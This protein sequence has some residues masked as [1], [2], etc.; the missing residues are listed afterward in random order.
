MNTR[1][2]VE[3]L[4]E[5][6]GDTIE[7]FENLEPVERLHSGFTHPSHRKA[8]NYFRRAHL[9]HVKGGDLVRSTLSFEDLDNLAFL[10][11]TDY[12]SRRTLRP[13]CCV[14]TGLKPGGQGASDISVYDDAIILHRFRRVPLADVRGF[15]TPK[16][17]TIFECAN[18]FI[19]PDGSYWT[20]ITFAELHSN[21]WRFQK[22]P[23]RLNTSPTHDFGLAPDYKEE[24]AFHDTEL[25]ETLDVMIGSHVTWCSFWHVEFAMPN[26]LSLLLPVNTALIPLLFRLREL[27]PHKSRRAAL[28]HLVRSHWRG[29]SELQ[30]EWEVQVAGYLR[31]KTSFDWFGIKVGIEPSVDM[32]KK[33]DQQRAI[34]PRPRRHK[35]Q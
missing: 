25:A 14:W 20:S 2:R 30:A 9:G 13:D 35:T 15:F 32:Q 31:G 7:L 26:G 16:A 3:R 29:L 22:A 18:A 19:N 6:L 24:S 1:E 8:L 17:A 23:A 33:I 11:A 27:E 21:G 4:L 28:L 12:E 10:A 34:H 5:F